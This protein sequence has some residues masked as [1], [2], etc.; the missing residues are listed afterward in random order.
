MDGGDDFDE[1]IARSIA[2]AQEEA[3]RELELVIEAIQCE[4]VD[5]ETRLRAQYAD[6]ERATQ[7]EMARL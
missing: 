5:E 4:R 7:Q 2:C 1:M 6:Y 3:A